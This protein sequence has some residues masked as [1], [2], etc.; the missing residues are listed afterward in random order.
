MYI[1]HIYK[2]QHPV[3]SLLCNQ[4]IQLYQ[5]LVSSSHR[6]LFFLYCLQTGVLI[7]DSGAA[8]TTVPFSCCVYVVAALEF[9]T[10]NTC[11]SKKVL[12]FQF[13][14][15]ISVFVRIHTGDV[16]AGIMRAANDCT[17]NGVSQSTR[18]TNNQQPTGNSIEI[19]HV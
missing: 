9:L 8:A 5:S 10:K 3:F 6:H 14:S 11:R 2:V 16:V 18:S 19:K 17:T 13:P 7:L 1:D 4:P 12:P 15:H